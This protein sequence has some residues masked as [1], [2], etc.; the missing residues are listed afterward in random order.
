[1]VSNPPYVP[2]AAAVADE[3]RHDPPEAV[4]AGPD[5]LALMPAVV[6]RAAQLLRRG[7]VLA[8]EH[9]ESHAAAVPELL[10]ADGRFTDIVDRHDLAGHPRYAVAYR[11]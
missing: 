5:G 6:A 7:G 8:V 1:M 2:Q 11:D 9:D 3:V 4:F 10:A